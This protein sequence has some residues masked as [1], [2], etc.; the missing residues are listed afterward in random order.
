MELAYSC[1][2]FAVP[3]SL[4]WLLAETIQSVI[5]KFVFPFAYFSILSSLVHTCLVFL[6]TWIAVVSACAWTPPT[7]LSVWALSLILQ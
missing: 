6:L 4:T 1:D 2:F 7:S 3:D 5:R